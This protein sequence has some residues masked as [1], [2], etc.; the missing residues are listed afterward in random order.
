MQGHALGH[1]A[2]VPQLRPYDPFDRAR[3]HFPQHNRAQLVA[4]GGTG[5]SPHHGR[6]FVDGQTGVAL[7]DG[8]TVREKYHLGKKNG[9]S[10]SDSKSNGNSDVQEEMRCVLG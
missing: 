6:S 1:F 8:Q 4:V 10:K 7:G 5:E 9:K 3:H 2:I